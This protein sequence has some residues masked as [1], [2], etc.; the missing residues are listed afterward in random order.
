M[1]GRFLSLRRLP[2][3]VQDEVGWGRGRGSLNLTQAQEIARLPDLRDQSLLALSVVEHNMS[4]AE[5][6]SVVQLVRDARDTCA[7]ATEKTLALRPELQRRHVLLGSIRDLRIQRRL[8]GMS[9]QVR[10]DLV[11][12]LIPADALSFSLSPTHFSVSTTAAVGNADK[13]EAKLNNFLEA[14]LGGGE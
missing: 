14:K 2:A 6:R 13:F 3:N 10:R 5:V 8:A 12:E 4:G 9:D 11:S 1:I 7:R